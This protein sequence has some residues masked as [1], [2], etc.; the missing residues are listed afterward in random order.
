MKGKKRSC[1]DG[2]G[3][4]WCS[5]QTGKVQEFRAFLHMVLIVSSRKTGRIA[6]LP[7]TAAH[8]SAHARKRPDYEQRKIRKV[9]GLRRMLPQCS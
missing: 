3:R 6:I 2:S 5:W 4:S 7:E 9:N 1:P 8:M